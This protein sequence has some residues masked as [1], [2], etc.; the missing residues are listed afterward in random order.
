[1][2]NTVIVEDNALEVRLNEADTYQSV[3]KE[4]LNGVDLSG[5]SLIRKAGFSDSIYLGIIANT[6]R[7]EACGG[8]LKYLLSMGDAE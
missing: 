3:T 2:E 1:M 6:P 8:Y 4:V 7:L 5:I